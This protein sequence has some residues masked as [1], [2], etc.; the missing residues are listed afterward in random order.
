MLIPLV[1]FGLNTLSRPQQDGHQTERTEG[2]SNRD[3]FRALSQRFLTS[4][5]EM[6]LLVVLSASKEQRELEAWN[7][8]VAL[9]RVQTNDDLVM[10][11]QVF[12][13]SSQVTKLL[14]AWLHTCSKEVV[15]G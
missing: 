8:E 1:A 4:R 11:L 10:T 5:L 15:G 6:Q 7:H 12:T 14:H 3:E 2:G 9:G 13:M